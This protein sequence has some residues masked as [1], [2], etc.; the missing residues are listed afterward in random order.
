MGDPQEE[1]PAQPQH[2]MLQAQVHLEQVEQLEV[3]PQAVEQP[4]SL[5]QN[6]QVTVLMPQPQLLQP[7]VLAL[8]PRQMLLRLRCPPPPWHLLP[9][10]HSDGSSCFQCTLAE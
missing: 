8:A 7:Q 4:Q 3:D 9:S 6:L 2:P 1:E 5:S 10:L